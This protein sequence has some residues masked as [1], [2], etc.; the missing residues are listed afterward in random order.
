MSNN[1]T[2]LQKEKD[3]ED[4]TLRR[5]TFR[6]VYDQIEFTFSYLEYNLMLPSFTLLLYGI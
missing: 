6:S 2:L 3:S 5:S 1:I 4:R